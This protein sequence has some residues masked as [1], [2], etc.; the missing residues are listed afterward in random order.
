MPHTLAVMRAL[1]VLA[2]GGLLL[3][4]GCG[5]GGGSSNSADG[6]LSI[7]TIAAASDRAAAEGSYRVEGS[8]EFEGGDDIPFAFEFEGEF[9][10]VANAAL[11]AYSSD[12]LDGAFNS[13][14][15]VVEGVLYVEASGLL[16]RFSF[17]GEPPTGVRWLKINAPELADAFSLVPGGDPTATLENLRGV[18][19]DVIEIG[20]EQ[21]RGVGTTQYRAEIDPDKARAGAS[22]KLG[23]LPEGQRE[24]VEDNLDRLGNEPIAVDVW[25]DDD[26]LVRRQ[27]MTFDAAIAAE[28]T[29]T[30]T[31]LE[32]FD[33]GADV[34]IE[35][36]PADETATFEEIFGVSP[37]D[38]D[39]LGSVL[40]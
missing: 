9:N 25:I 14:T 22:E 10:T 34:D 23:E 38:I 19:D 32:F 2:V 39:Q 6:E 12:G 40:S 5:N 26:G 36:P 31:T 20:T 16:E 4:A 21:I 30:V 24:A 18:S 37:E 3:V 29:A 17:M 11:I 28:P 15:R 1:A 7:A 27:E 13:E 33:Y 35:A 8:V